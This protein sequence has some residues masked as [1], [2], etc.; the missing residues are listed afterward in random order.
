[1]C[2]EFNTKI[3]DRC[4]S[5][6]GNDGYTYHHYLP[7]RYYWLSACIISNLSRAKLSC[8]DDKDIVQISLASKACLLSEKK[9]KLPFTL[10]KKCKDFLYHIKLDELIVLL[11]KLAG[12]RTLPGISSHFT[13]DGID[14]NNLA[15]LCANPLF[16][17]FFGPPSSCR[18]DDPD[19]QCEVLWPRSTP[20]DKCPKGRLESLRGALVSSCD[21]ISTANSGVPITV[22]I[23]SEIVCQIY[24][25]LSALITSYNSCYLFNPSDWGMNKKTG[26]QTWGFV[27]NEKDLS[28][29]AKAGRVLFLDNTGRSSGKNIANRNDIIPWDTIFKGNDNLFYFY[30]TKV[31]T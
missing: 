19:D 16:G 6:P 15:K 13:N 23:N 14:F 10:N 18:S 5:P 9:K 31:T 8:I 26:N 20:A 30:T 4:G 21:N 27:K 17:G 25:D 12:G 24:N 7:W 22:V 28:K 1:M 3:P 2:F 29:G 11:I